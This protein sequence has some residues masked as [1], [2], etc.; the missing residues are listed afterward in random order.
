VA[1]FIHE[2]IAAANRKADLPTYSYD[3]DRNRASLICPSGKKWQYGYN[4]RN[5]LTAIGNEN[6]TVLASYQYD[7]AGNRQQRAL[8]NGVITEYAPVDALNRSGWSRHMFN[9]AELGRFDYGFDDL[10]R[11]KYEQP[12]HGTADGYAYDPASEVTAFNRE[13]TLSNGAVRRAERGRSVNLDR[14]VGN[15]AASK[16][17]NI[18]W[19]Q[20]EE[21][22]ILVWNVKC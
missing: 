16:H 14:E 3:G 15:G 18:V 22:G 17:F 7:K 9:G 21:I 10:S 1:R 11:L 20:E 12:D 2:G 5:Q 6:W 13:G 8:W 19:K 4:Q